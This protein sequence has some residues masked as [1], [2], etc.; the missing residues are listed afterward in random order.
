MSE[1]LVFSLYRES[2]DLNKNYDSSILGK[3]RPT[4][5][6][7]KYLHSITSNNYPHDLTFE[8]IMHEI[9]NGWKTEQYQF[10]QEF[11]PNSIW[12]FFVIRKINKRSSI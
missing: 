5:F 1:R 7:S 8:K 4:T 11:N 3:L 10:T 2:F 6:K 9:M 12:K